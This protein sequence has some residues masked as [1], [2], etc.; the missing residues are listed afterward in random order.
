MEPTMTGTANQVEW[1]GRIKCQVNDEFDRVARSFRTVAAR[2][3][4]ARRVGTEAIL[5]I[6]EDQRAVVMSRHE[7]EYFIKYWQEIGDQVRQLIFHDP[8][9]QEIKSDRAARP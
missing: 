4:D 6:L 8:R 3:S 5:A 1:A 9:Y 7:A 2:Q